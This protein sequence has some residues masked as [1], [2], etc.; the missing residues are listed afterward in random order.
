MRGKKIVVTGGA[1]FIGSNLVWSFCEDN[2]VTVV[3]NLSS[4]K[5]ENIKTLVDSKRIEF[6]KTSITDYNNM[7]KCMRGVDCVFHE[8][9]IPSVARSVKNPIATN[10]AGITGTLALL[11]AARERDVSRFVFASS[12]SVYGEHRHCQNTR[13][14]RST[15]FPPTLSP[16]SRPKSTVG[17]FASCTD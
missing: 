14:C 7:R 1:G 3:D 11:S 12:S 5:M 8:A 16:R 9:A 2:D 17:C 13:R 6:L 15:Q 10:E 4:G